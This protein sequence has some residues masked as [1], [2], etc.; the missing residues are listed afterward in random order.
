MLAYLKRFERLIAWIL[1]VLLALV[2]SLATVDL[3]VDLIKNVLYETP[4]F[5][6][7]IDQ[8]LNLF[9]F[10][11]IIVLGLELLETVKAYLRDD[12]IR[13]E[14]VLIVAII[15]LARKVIILEFKEP[16]PLTLLGL[17]ALVICLAVAYRL[18]M[19]VMRSDADSTAEK[20]H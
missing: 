14:V 15:A 9:G 5:L 4:R 8:L 19:H 12:I 10:F 16:T 17:A 3:A 2:I 1:A 11:L 20:K 18:I 6:I 13:V 7:R